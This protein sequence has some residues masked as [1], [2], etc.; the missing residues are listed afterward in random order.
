MTYLSG[1]MRAAQRIGFVPPVIHPV[2]GGSIACIEATGDRIMPT[3][4]YANRYV[5]RIDVRD[6]RIAGL[7]ECLNPVT[8]AIAFGRP[9]GPQPQ[10]A[11]R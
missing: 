9:I 1:A 2:E 7:R 5:F 8:A 3:G 4:A 11:A 10:P 6:G